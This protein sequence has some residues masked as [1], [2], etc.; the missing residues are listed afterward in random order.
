MSDKSHEPQD[1]GK[2]ER[3]DVLSTSSGLPGLAGHFETFMRRFRNLSFSLL[4]NT[5]GMG[6]S[7]HR[8]KT[9]KL[10]W[11]PGIYRLWLHRR[12][13]PNRWPRKPLPQSELSV[14][15]LWPLNSKSQITNIKQIY[16]PKAEPKLV[17][18]LKG[19]REK[20]RKARKLVFR[21]HSQQSHG[22]STTLL[23]IS[24]GILDL[25]F[26]TTT[27]VPLLL[28]GDLGGL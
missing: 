1:E 2:K 19:H 17:K 22:T 25:D 6:H 27:P 10:I 4:K 15:E 18:F 11:I 3:V 28:K 23:P 13:G 20:E 24:S 21:G 14:R 26:V 9:K 12:N 8:E 16:P 5:R 7:R